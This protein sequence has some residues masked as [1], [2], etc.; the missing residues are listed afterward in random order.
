[1]LS[2]S[3][4]HG[5]CK[6]GVRQEGC[7]QPFDVGRVSFVGSGAIW[8]VVGDERRLEVVLMPQDA[9]EGLLVGVEGVLHQVLQ[10][11]RRVF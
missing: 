6:Q 3:L 4:K 5:R 11:A 7:G 9:V 10:H 8:S 1:M 2:Q